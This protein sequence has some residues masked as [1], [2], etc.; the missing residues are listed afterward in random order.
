[1]DADRAS[2]NKQCLTDFG[3][4]FTFGKQ[5]EHGQL[6]FGQSECLATWGLRWTLG[7]FGQVDARA[8]REI[9]YRV[10]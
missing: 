5:A 9:R 8:T 3:I 6:A 1:M 2:T 7:R 10:F 4:A